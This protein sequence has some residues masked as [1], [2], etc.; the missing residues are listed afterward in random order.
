M[1]IQLQLSGYVERKGDDLAPL[2]LTSFGSSRA[3]DT[4]D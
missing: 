3:I 4:T 1:Q 2:L